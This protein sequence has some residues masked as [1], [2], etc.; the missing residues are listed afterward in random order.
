[1]KPQGKALIR[2]VVRVRTC[3]GLKGESVCVRVCVPACVSAYRFMGGMCVWVCGRVCGDPLRGTVLWAGLRS[4]SAKM[5][6]RFLQPG[7]THH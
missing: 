3:V 4:G 7:L 2:K 5:R 6:S 1:M